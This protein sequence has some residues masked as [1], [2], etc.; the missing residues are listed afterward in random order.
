MT[1]ESYEGLSIGELH[2]TFPCSCSKGSHQIQTENVYVGP[3]SLHALAEDIQKRDISGSVT[4]IC[5]ETT[6]NLR[7]K[8]ILE[9]LEQLG[10]TARSCLIT[11]SELHAD[12]RLLGSVL[13]RTDENTSLLIAVG[14]GTLNDTARYI[15]CRLHIPYIIYGTV[16]S[17]DG[18]ASTVSPILIDGFKRTYSAVHPVSVIC[19]VEAM[20]QAPRQMTAAGLGD[21][22]GKYTALSDWTLSGYVNGEEKCPGIMN[23]MARAVED[24][25]KAAPGLETG[26]P[27]AVTKLA[28]ALVLSGLAMQM[29]G[30]SRPAS[31]CEHHVAHF[32]EMIHIARGQGSHFHGDKVGVAELLVLDFYR[33]FFDHIRPVKPVDME[34][35]Q[36]QTRK[37]FGSLYE[38]VLRETGSAQEVPFEIQHENTIRHW[39]EIKAMADSITAKAF[40]IREMIDRCGGPVTPAQ[41]GATPEDVRNALCYALNVRTRFTVLRLALRWGV[42]FDIVDEMMEDLYGK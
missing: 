34:Q 30:N 8:A 33:R 6:Y 15:S 9:L 20:A 14:G 40:S 3:N 18:F 16:A 32:W 39:A 23:M 1:H 41:V 26:D 17:M 35:Y 19:D 29:Y 21:I 38:E 12:A 10:I 5:D 42:L 4:V 11:G 2:G 37:A 31:G 27:A 13:L 22:L 25:E 7:G 24:C 28:E 36:A